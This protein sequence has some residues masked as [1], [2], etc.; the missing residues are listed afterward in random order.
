MTQ[1]DELAQALQL[2]LQTFKELGIAYRIGGSLASSLWGRARATLDV[3]LVAQLMPEQVRP[4]CA[5]LQKAYYVDEGA[6]RQ[7]ITEGRAF[8]LIHLDTMIK[9]DIFVLKTGPFDLASFQRSAKAPLGNLPEVFF[10]TAEDVILRKLE[11]YRA[12]GE[13]SERQWSDVLG[14]LQVQSGAL[15]WAYLNDW[16]GKLNLSDLLQN[17]SREAQCP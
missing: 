9:L 4:F 17:A 12:G 15:D 7:A 3:D 2:L 5:A 14:L 13:I 8:N 10:C 6:M 16:A 1:S 11:W